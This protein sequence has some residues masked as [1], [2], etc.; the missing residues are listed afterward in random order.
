MHDLAIS[1]SLGG[2]LYHDWKY[3]GNY[4]RHCNENL[5]TYII[6]VWSGFPC[7]PYKM[8]EVKSCMSNYPGFFY[9]VY[10]CVNSHQH[11]QPQRVLCSWL[12]MGGGALTL[13][14][15]HG[16][17]DSDYRARGL[18]RVFSKMSGSSCE[19]TKKKKKKEKRKKKEQWEF[20]RFLPIFQPEYNFRLTLF[21]DKINWKFWWNV[22][23][24]GYSVR[25]CRKMVLNY[26]KWGSM[27][28][29]I[30]PIIPVINF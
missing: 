18:S 14:V 10:T 15:P 1:S 22:K 19:K 8:K 13:K 6:L 11:G 29:Q 2:L 20:N 9:T 23:T 12:I 27:G 24:G 30:R 3:H 25:D 7:F 17:L 28:D 26:T 5:A 21:Y 4:Y 16:W